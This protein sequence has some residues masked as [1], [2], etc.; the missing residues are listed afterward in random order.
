[1]G[2]IVMLS[3][4]QTKAKIAII[5]KDKDISQE[6]LNNIWE[7]FVTFMDDELPSRI[8]SKIFTNPIFHSSAAGEKTGNIETEELREPMFITRKY[9]TDVDDFILILS[10]LRKWKQMQDKDIHISIE[11]LV[12]KLKFPLYL[13]NNKYIPPDTYYHLK[14]ITK[15][16]EEFINELNASLLD[17]K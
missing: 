5:F 4:N 16:E 11:V 6:T 12:N 2:D 8:G 10:A 17:T 13:R 7:A 3:I 15:Q 1:M 14:V 9:I